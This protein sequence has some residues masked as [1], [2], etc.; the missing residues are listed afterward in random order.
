VLGRAVE[1]D[2]LEVTTLKDEEGWEVILLSGEPSFDL[3]NKT[4]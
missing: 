3:N 4:E 2:W 1:Q